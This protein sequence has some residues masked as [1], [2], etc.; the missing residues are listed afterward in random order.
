MPAFAHLL[1]CP[2]LSVAVCPLIHTPFEEQGMRVSAVLVE[3]PQGG[4]RILH[5]MGQGSRLSLAAPFYKT[6]HNL[7]CSPAPQLG[8]GALRQA[9]TEPLLVDNSK[10]NK[11][12]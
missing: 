9:G 12:K 4:G 5:C 10:Q 3:G 6:D 11:Q 2:G 7:H 1:R 8:Q